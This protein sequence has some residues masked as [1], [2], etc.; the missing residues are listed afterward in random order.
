[1]NSC[2]IRV[3]NKYI[4]FS[5]YD[6]IVKSVCYYTRTF[7]KNSAKLDGAHKEFQKAVDASICRY[8]PE[9]GLLSI[10]SRSNASQKR[11]SMLSDMHFR[12]LSQKITLLKRT[13]EAARQ[14]ESTK[15]QN[16]GG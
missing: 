14:L 10:I 16:I 8:L 7:L 6:T 1:M 13:E 2:D 15:L 4:K 9:L 12:N 11:A 5:Y 3:K